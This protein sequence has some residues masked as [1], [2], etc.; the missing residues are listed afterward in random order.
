MSVLWVNIYPACMVYKL[1]LYVKLSLVWG[2]LCFVYQHLVL[3][4]F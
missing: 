2:G 3:T 4:S 1:F